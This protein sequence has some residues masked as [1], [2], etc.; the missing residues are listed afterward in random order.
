MNDGEANL[1]EGLLR[2]ALTQP[3]HPWLQHGRDGEMKRGEEG[4]GKRLIVWSADSDHRN[5]GKHVHL[6]VCVCACSVGVCYHAFGLTARA[7]ISYI[8]CHMIGMLEQ[9]SDPVSL[10]HSPA[11]FHHMDPIASS[12]VFPAISPSVWFQ[13]DESHW[14]CSVSSGGCI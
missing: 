8:S 2:V 1:G 14:G 10:S 5:G 6:E 13:H 11:N 7:A 3:T 12:Y 4:R 9:D